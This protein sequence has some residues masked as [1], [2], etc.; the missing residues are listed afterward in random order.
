MITTSPIDKPDKP[1]SPLRQK[2]EREIRQY[3]LSPQLLAHLV[4]VPLAGLVSVVANLLCLKFAI[5]NGLS[6]QISWALAFEIGT[7]VSFGSHQ[8]VSRRDNL[9]ASSAALLGRVAR[10]QAGAML[11][12]LVNVAVF[13]LL[14]HHG[15]S[16]LDADLAG[17]TAGFCLNSTLGLHYTFAR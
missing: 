3:V 8:L 15:V 7:L 16:Y 6:I 9:P 4:G 12:L 17:I 5:S 2:V 11:S 13:A 10:F 1:V 14:L